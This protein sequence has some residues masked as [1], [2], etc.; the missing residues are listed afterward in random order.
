MVRTAREEVAV[1]E[2]VVALV[3]VVDSKGSPGTTMVL[4]MKTDTLEA[5]DAHKEMERD[6]VGLWVDTVVVVVVVAMEASAVESRSGTGHGNGFKRDGAGRGNWG[7]NED[8]IPPATEESAAVVEKSL[9][10]EKEG[11]E[12]EANKETP[13]EEKAEKE[14]EDNDMTLEEYEK[15]LEEKRNALQ[16][17]K[18][19]ERKLGTEKDKRPVEKEEKTKKSLS[20]NEFLKPANGEIYRGGY[21]GGRE[22][23]GGR[24]PRE[25]T[26]GRGR[27]QE[28]PMEEKTRELLH[29][30][31]S[32][33]H[34]KLKTPHKSLLWESRSSTIESDP[35]HAYSGPSLFPRTLKSMS[36]PLPPLHQS[37]GLQQTHTLLQS[38]PFEV[39]KEHEEQAKA[40]LDDENSEVLASEDT[41]GGVTVNPI[42]NKQRE[43]RPAYERKRGHFTFKPTIS[44]SPQKEP[45]FDPSKYPKPEEYFAAYESFLIAQREWQKQTGTFVKVTHQYQPPCLRRRPELPGRKR[46]TYKH[47]Y[48]D[49]FLID[50]KA[51]E[52]KNHIPFEQSLEENA[53]AHV[54]TVEQSL[55]ENTAAHVKTADR[56]VDD[57]TAAT[58]KNLEN[59]L[60]ELLAYSPEELEGDAAVKLL[61]ERLN[62][63]PNYKEMVS[64]PEIPE[65]PDVRR[66]DFKATARNP[67]KPRTALSNIQNLLKGINS[68]AS[69]KKSQASPSFSPE[70]QFSFPDRLN[71]LPGDQQPGEVDIAK[72]LNASLGSSVANDTDEVIPNA[73]PT[74]HVASEFNS[75]VQKSSCEGG[76]DTLSGVHRSNSSPDRNA[77]NCVDD[78]ITDINPSTLKVNV[79]VQTKENEGDVLMDESEANR[80]TGR[81]ENDVDFS[82]KTKQLDNLAE[83]APGEDARMDHFTV[84]DESIPYQQEQYNT[85][86]GSFEHEEHIQGQHEEE[87]DN[88]DTTC[89]VQVEDVQQEAHNSSPKQTNKRSK[90]GSCDGKMKKRSKTVHGESEKDKQTKTLSRESGA[91]KQ[92][93]GK[94]NERKEKTQKKTVTRESKMFSRRKSLAVYGTNWETGVRRSTRIKSRPLEYWRGERFLYGRVHES[95]ATVIGIK[96]ESPGNK[97]KGE[98]RALK[99]KSFVSDDYRELVESTALH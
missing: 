22:G 8:E 84:E 99:V 17:T 86:D 46:G 27:G 79:D 36:I 29:Q 63:K 6:V 66:M 49:S 7:T 12:G 96:Y 94:E 21:R 54:K 10:V 98:T 61:Q 69:R 19:E 13:V 38:L 76:S 11:D 15:V 56:E 62:I 82:E 37:D 23:R 52:K 59:I 57:S 50:L 83:D 31:G 1:V 71:L 64:F 68:D 35:L 18:I 25:G 9:P 74:V 33:L 89:G 95:L 77:D 65:F 58:D 47:T 39:S 34:Q 90:R 91:K 93:K 4:L 60:T 51:S 70:D 30:K 16:T 97:G 26:E 28:E 81:R 73:S 2:Y 48:T 24:G 41:N 5:T 20:I 40:I 78:S 87:N 42:P 3:G 88:T 55:E 85:M 53:A 72:D 45:T 43:R 14:P 44:E 75:S 92:T 67:S 32:L 80:N